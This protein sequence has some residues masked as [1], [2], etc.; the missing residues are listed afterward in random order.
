MLAHADA[1]CLSALSSEAYNVNARD[2][3]LARATQLPTLMNGYARSSCAAAKPT[4]N[5]QP[6]GS[7]KPPPSSR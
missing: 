1:S 2:T 6:S 5:A 3:R 4:L 7:L